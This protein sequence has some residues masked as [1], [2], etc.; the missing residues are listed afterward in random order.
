[1]SN[2]NL[3][4]ISYVVLGLVTFLGRGTS[5]DMKRLANMSVGYFWT[6][7]H[8]QLYAEPERLV[9]MGLLEETREEGGRRRRIYS[10]TDAGLEE[11]KD[12]LS[13]PQ[14]PRVE[15]RDMGTLKLFFGSLTS[16]ESIRKLAERQVEMNAEMMKEHEQLHEMFGNVTGLDAPLAT[17]RLGDMIL[18]TCDRF[19]RDIAANPPGAKAEDRRGAV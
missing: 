12:W 10:I 19:W 2:A 17:L 6:F 3:T 1:M 18:E 9:A 7:P 8:S 14:T 5:Y 4:P 16:P 11:L 13:D 15:M